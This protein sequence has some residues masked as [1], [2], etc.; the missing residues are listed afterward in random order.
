MFSGFDS[1]HLS[2]D[3][4]CGLRFCLGVSGFSCSILHRVR[5]Y[6]SPK[7]RR[8][9]R[10]RCVRQYARSVMWTDR[11]GVTICCLGPMGC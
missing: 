3:V 5:Q 2:L 11:R 4:A 6:H 9:V 8:A 10:G 7:R 1:F